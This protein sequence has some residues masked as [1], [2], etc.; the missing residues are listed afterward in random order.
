MIRNR[1]GADYPKVDS[2]SRSAL[3][4]VKLIKIWQIGLNIFFSGFYRIV[5]VYSTI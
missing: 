2:A 3:V 4:K 1:M 5:Q